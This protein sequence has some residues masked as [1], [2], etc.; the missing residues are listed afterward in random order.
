MLAIVFVDIFLTIYVSQF[1]GRIRMK[2]VSYKFQIDRMTT[3][4]E[5]SENHNEKLAHKNEFKSHTYTKRSHDTPACL[6]ANALQNNQLN[7]YMCLRVVVFFPFV[8][9]SPEKLRITESLGNSI[10]DR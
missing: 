10:I 5:Q 9:I 1:M 4:L 6:I 2:N 3:I 8:S 7:V